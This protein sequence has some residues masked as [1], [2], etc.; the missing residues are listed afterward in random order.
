MRNKKTESLKEFVAEAEEILDGLDQCLIEID[1]MKGS[2]DPKPEV[3]NT[4]FRG[5]HTL[6]GISGMAGQDGISKLSHT[7]EEML[8]RLRMGKLT[9]TE[10]AVSTL[11]EGV[12]TLRHLVHGIQSPGA[13]QRSLDSLYQK[14]ALLVSAKDQPATQ[15][16]LEQMGI[17]PDLAKVLTEYES[18]RLIE[19]IRQGNQILEVKAHFG[20]QSFDKELSA[21]MAKVQKLGEVITTLPSTNPTADKGIEFNIILGTKADKESIRREL[22]GDEVRVEQI[23]TRAGGKESAAPKPTTAADPAASLKRMSQNIRV[24]IGKLDSLLNIVGELVLNKAVINQI[25]KEMMQAQG[26]VGSVAEIFKASQELDRRVTELQEGLIEIR[27]IP[28]AQVFEK[29][30][31]AARKLSREL[32][33]DVDLIVSGEETRLDKS[34]VE[35]VADPLLHLIRN[36]LDHGIE[37]KAERRKSHKPETG[38]IR[39]NAVQRGSAVAIELADD[40]KGINLEKVREKAVQRGLADAGKSYSQEDLLNFLFLPGCRTASQVTEGSGRGVGLDVVSKNIS[41][42]NGM[43]DIETTEG[44]GTKFTITLPITLVIIKALIIR[45]GTEQY[46]IPLNAVSESLMIP[47]QEVKTVEEKEVIQLRDHTLPLLRV[48]DIFALPPS[49]HSD[50]RVYIIV[51]G[52]AEKRVGLIVDAIEGQQEIVIKSIGET[53]KA[54]PGIAG[55]TELGN[56]RTILVLDVGTL[57]E[58]ST[59][60]RFT[61][62]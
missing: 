31:L 47:R 21:V 59:R 35:A 32:G 42:L 6:K 46:A 61:Q 20:L 57:I 49:A 1:S 41:K 37:S 62:S 9:F 2:G 13:A 33:K 24:D 3:V 26:L 12:E 28:V 11:M 56:R 5:A 52:V 40:G 58:E 36:S 4:L 27:M 30:T 55:A 51:V 14:I 34:M 29:L 48:S 39:L 22:P 54:I 23:Q 19:N 16:S 53:L 10:D 25:G 43:V 8:D 50:E 15:T 45:V 7:L 60:V 44:K 38:T 18:H 17:S